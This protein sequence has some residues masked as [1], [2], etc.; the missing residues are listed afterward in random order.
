MRMKR[1]L[2]PVL[3]LFLASGVVQAMDFSADMAMTGKEGSMTGKIQAKKDKVRMEVESPEKMILITRMDK[4]V[5]WSLMPS[6]HIYLELPMDLK[7]KP[8]TEIENEV[9]RKQVGEETVNGHPAK[10][11]LVTVKNGNN[12]EQLYQWMATDINFP[13]KSAALDGSWVQ[14]FKNVK[15]GSPEDGLFEIPAGY[16]KMDLPTGMRPGKPGK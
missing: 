8:I 5:T 10:K 16:T 2:L 14:E 6:E 3:F 11:Y 1:V 15:T 4:K 9:E 13:I 12:K 7:S